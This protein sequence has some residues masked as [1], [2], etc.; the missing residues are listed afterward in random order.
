MRRETIAVAVSGTAG[1]ASGTGVSSVPLSGQIA[2]VKVAY[3]TQA[4]T[5]DVTITDDLG[6]SILTLTN[7]NSDGWWYPHPEIHDNTGSLI[8]KHTC[9]F[10]VD[11]YV[12]VNVAQSNAGSVTVTL[13]VNE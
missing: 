8:N 10:S 9:P 4:A 12:T 11:G 2:G 3:T 13:I 7:N 1:S 5:A 6:Q